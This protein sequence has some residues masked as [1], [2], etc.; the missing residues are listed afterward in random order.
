MRVIGLMSGT[1]H[2]AI[3]AVGADI[4]LRVVAQQ[5]V[6]QFVILHPVRMLD[7]DQ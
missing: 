1:S 4:G 3:D 5:F 6:T 2:D 7:I